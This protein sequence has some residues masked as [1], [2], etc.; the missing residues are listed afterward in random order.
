MCLESIY[1]KA[2]ELNRINIDV[3]AGV[4]LQK[5]ERETTVTGGCED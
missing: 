2:L 5:S 1:S 3:W 4:I